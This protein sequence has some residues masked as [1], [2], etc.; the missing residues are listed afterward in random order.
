MNNTSSSA[1]THWRAIIDQQERSGLSVARFCHERGIAASSL[2]A[3]K[4]RLRQEGHSAGEA[5]PAGGS[6]M[7]AFVQLAA[8]RPAGRRAAIELRLGRGRRL[9]LRPGFDA[10]TLA[11]AL[12]VLEG[13]QATPQDA[14]PE[15]R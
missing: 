1:R 14:R 8:G 11:T 7:P 5:S 6:N 2:F 4:R 15:G 13:A 3:W 12:A 9:L 10:P